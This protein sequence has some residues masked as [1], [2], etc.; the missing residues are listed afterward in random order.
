MA[1]M[2]LN[3]FLLAARNGDVFVMKKH[4]DS[5]ID[6]HAFGDLALRL[7]VKFN[8]SKATIFLLARG[9]NINAV[10]DA[11]LRN[12]ALKGKTDKVKILLEDYPCSDNA[13]L[14]AM[15]NAIFGRHEDIINLLLPFAHNEAVL[16]VVKFCNDDKVNALFKDYLT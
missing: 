7:T 14:S 13:K 4:L 12:A 15:Y 6:I 1:N 11:E 2:D 10:Y 9:A 3:F 5:G 16:N 8:H